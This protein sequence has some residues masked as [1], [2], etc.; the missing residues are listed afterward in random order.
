M[1]KY[2][3]EEMGVIIKQERKVYVFDINNSMSHGTNKQ[4]HQ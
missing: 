2:N 1:T 4:I 3:K